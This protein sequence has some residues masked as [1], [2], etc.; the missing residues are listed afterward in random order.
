MS[1]L[2]T[3]A[4]INKVAVFLLLSLSTQLI[5]FT[6]SFFTEIDHTYVNPTSDIYI[7]VINDVFVNLATCIKEVGYNKSYLT[8]PI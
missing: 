1:F 3:S 4:L 5:K 8:S 6:R 7:D 2:I